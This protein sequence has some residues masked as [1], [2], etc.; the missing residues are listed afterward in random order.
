MDK[1]TK[2]NKGHGTR[3]N[4][5]NNSTIEGKVTNMSKEVVK[6]NTGAMTAAD[7]VNDMRSKLLKIADSLGRTT[8]ADG[9]WKLNK[10][11][12]AAVIASQKDRGPLA[13]MVA[14]FGRVDQVFGG[15]MVAAGQIITAC[16]SL[17]KTAQSLV[18][19][20]VAALNGL[21]ATEDTGVNGFAYAIFGND[22]TLLEVTGKTHQSKGAKRVSAYVAAAKG[23]LKKPRTLKP[24][25][26]ADGDGD[27]T[28]DGDGDGGKTSSESGK[29]EGV[30]A[31]VGEFFMD[32]YEVAESFKVAP[33]MTAQE[34]LAA[35]AKSIDFPVD[36]FLQ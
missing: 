26:D 32:L 27:K 13:A 11:K 2:A 19:N 20:D 18:I 9:K 15:S 4:T 36:A 3:V 8:K 5:T 28:G 6:A 22:P 14:S 34:I 12:A 30:S 16:L 33:K 29:I 10:T 25:P 31:E 23:T 21:P 24:G 35:L 17:D 7:A 1:V